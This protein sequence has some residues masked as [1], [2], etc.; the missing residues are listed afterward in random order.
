MERCQGGGC[1]V[2]S[3][4]DWVIP[5]K[6]PPPKAPAEPG[7]PTIKEATDA[8]LAKCENRGIR[9]TTFA[10]YR[11]FVR[12]LIAYAEVRGYTRVDQLTVVDMDR[13][14]A[15]WSDGIRSR[16]KKLE[17]L[18]SFVRFCKKTWPRLGRSR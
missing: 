7:A 11:T 14:Y 15:S 2:E 18:K 10:K 3:A 6:V 13:F 4:G 9:R 17:R 16:A 5:A 8:F 12:Q 1:A